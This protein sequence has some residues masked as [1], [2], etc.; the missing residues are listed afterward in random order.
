MRRNLEDYKE[1]RHNEIEK[2]YKTNANLKLKYAATGVISIA[3]ILMLIL[4]FCMDYIS[5]G[6]TLFLRGCVG[7]C[8]I[9]F[10]I[11]V[12]VLVYR[13]HRDYFRQHTNKP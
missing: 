12:A 8:A 7:L 5:I 10:V 1:Q 9:A 6:I 2:L 4:A 11:M 3:I 13:I